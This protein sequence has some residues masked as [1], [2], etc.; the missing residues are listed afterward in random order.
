M[1]L[2]ATAEGTANYSKG[3]AGSLAPGHFRQSQNLWMSTIGLGSYLG[4]ADDQTDEAYRR[5]V[6]QAVELG[7]NVIDSAANYRF[8]RSE[9]SIGAALD[10]LFREGRFGRDG[11]VVSTKGGF[12]PFDFTSR[13][14]GRR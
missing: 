2:R 3:F 6:I 9:R 11:I 12:I 8:Q 14:R 10:D 1:N 7:C 13:V 4:N 5:A